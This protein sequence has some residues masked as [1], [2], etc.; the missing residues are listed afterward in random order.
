ML[1]ETTNGGERKKIEQLLLQEV[2]FREK[3]ENFIETKTDSLESYEWERMIK[4]CDGI[5][6]MHEKLYYKTLG[7]HVFY[8][9]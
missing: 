4:L 8:G 3:T 1:K 9:G 7:A 6:N 5:G 2:Y